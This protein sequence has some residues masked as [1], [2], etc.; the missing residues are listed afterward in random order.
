MAEGNWDGFVTM[1]D[2]RRLWDL[3]YPWMQRRIRD[4]VLEA[5]PDARDARRKLLRREQVEALIGPARHAS[6]EGGPGAVRQA[7]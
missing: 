6:A 4:G 3:T 5:V 1:A 2:A 7:A